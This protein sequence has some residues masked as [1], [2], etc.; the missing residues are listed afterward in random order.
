MEAAA[1]QVQWF[2]MGRKELLAELR[3]G[4]AD[5]AMQGVLPTWHNFVKLIQL[6]GKV[7]VLDEGHACDEYTTGLVEELVRWLATLCCT[8]VVMIATLPGSTRRGL[9]A[10][11]RDGVGE[12]EATIEDTTYP[13]LTISSATLVRSRSFSAS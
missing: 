12:P 8:V 2:S 13:R 6:A 1:T 11:Y 3:V 7:C 9:V 4:T 10:A 5:K